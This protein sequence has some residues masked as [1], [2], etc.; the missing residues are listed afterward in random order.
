MA[1]R[2]FISL[3]PSESGEGEFIVVNTSQIIWAERAKNGK[4]VVRLTDGKTINLGN[5]SSKNLLRALG[6]SGK[7]KL[8]GI[9]L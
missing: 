3:T 9:E 6:I 5:D 8:R 1:K 2:S 7:T 4:L